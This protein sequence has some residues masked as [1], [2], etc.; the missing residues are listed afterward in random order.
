MKVLH[1]VATPRAAASNTMRVADAF[2]QAL[3]E[4]TPE[5]SIDTLDLFAD[6]IPKVAGSNIEAK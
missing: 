2:F 6:A 3:K 4:A 5:C 1:I